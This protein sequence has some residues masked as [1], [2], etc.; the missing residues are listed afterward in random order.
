[1]GE[2]RKP[3]GLT[4]EEQRKLIPLRRRFVASGEQSSDSP[5]LISEV[6]SRELRDLLN[7]GDG[8]RYEK[9]EDGP[10]YRATKIAEDYLDYFSGDKDAQ[11]TKAVLNQL[12]TWSQTTFPPQNYQNYGIVHDAASA[13]FF[14]VVKAFRAQLGQEFLDNLRQTDAKDVSDAFEMRGKLVGNASSLVERAKARTKIPQDQVFLKEFVKEFADFS[15]GSIVGPTIEA[16]AELAFT[17]IDKL[18]PKLK[19]GAHSPQAPQS[20]KIS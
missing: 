5:I 7:M 10:Y 8:K 9:Q 6:T 13:G 18:W 20:D 1:M 2:K 16:G 15:A 17:V 19:P 14:L 3:T 11:G 12:G 4:L